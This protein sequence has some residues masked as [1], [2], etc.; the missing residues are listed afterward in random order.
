VELEETPAGVVEH[1]VQHDLDTACMRFIKQR[2][3][4][5]VAPKQRIHVVV[6]VC[7]VAMVR[8]RL[9]YRVEVDRVDPQVR[10]VIK[11]LHHPE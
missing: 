8:R 5:G 10:Q 9:K 6:V 7:M 11:V 4:R 3:Q 1:P 2:P